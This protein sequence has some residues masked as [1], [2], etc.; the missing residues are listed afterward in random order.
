[1]AERRRF[2]IEGHSL[3]GFATKKYQNHRPYPGGPRVRRIKI[4]P[5]GIAQGAQDL[6]SKAFV[7]ELDREADLTHEPPA[8]PPGI[9]NGPRR[10][11]AICRMSCIS[12]CE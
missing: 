12:Y 10:V 9:K 6:M 5:D 11:I 8:I 3:T 1:V 7:K 2:R 4:G